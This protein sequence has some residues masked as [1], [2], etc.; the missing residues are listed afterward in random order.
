[1]KNSL[2]IPYTLCFCIIDDS[3]LMLYRNNPPNQYLWNG[4]GGKIEPGEAV[5]ESLYRES[6]EEA[7]VDFSNV[8]V[9]YT[10]VVCW[11]SSDNALKGMYCFFAFLPSSYYFVEEKKT[12]EGILAWKKHSWVVDA[13]NKEVVS[14]I[15]QFL[16]MMWSEKQQFLY[17]CFYVN[18]I[19]QHLTVETLPK[20]YNVTI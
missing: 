1:M 9:Q 20:K 8:R 6:F 11:N 3:I 15:S 2:I 13:N 5:K 4:I 17:R 16:P 7:G 12:R 19:L 18:H 14:N 10:G